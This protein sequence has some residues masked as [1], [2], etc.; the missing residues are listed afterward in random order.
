MTIV[1][2]KSLD[3]CFQR[4]KIVESS[5]NYWKVSKLAAVEV[6]GLKSYIGFRTFYKGYFGSGKTV[7]VKPHKKYSN[8]LQMFSAKGMHM[9]DIF[10]DWVEEEI[11]PKEVTVIPIVDGLITKW[12]D[13]FN[14]TTE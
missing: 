3:K 11:K 7:I 14:E 12:E 9:M 2:L 8:I 10:N 13:L 6:L 5:K 1:R 4:C